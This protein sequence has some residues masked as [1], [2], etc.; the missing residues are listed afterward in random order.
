MYGWIKGEPLRFLKGHND[1]G[2]GPEFRVDAETECW[3]WRRA[4]DSNGYG[5]AWAGGG[6]HRVAHV[7]MYERLRGPVPEGLELDHLCR[8][9]ACV[10]P[11]HLEPVTHAENIR[12]GKNTKLTVAL[13]AEIRTSSE[14]YRAIAARLGVAPETVQSVRQGVSWVAV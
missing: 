4:L 10:R 11:D 1:R 8:N 9:P 14:H 3:V 12:R 6:S 2:P 7:V 13:A 5:R